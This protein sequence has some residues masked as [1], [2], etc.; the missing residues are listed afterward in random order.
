MTLQSE[1][2][3]QSVA[4]VQIRQKLY[5]L[6]GP[7]SSQSPSKAEAQE[8]PALVLM[9]VTV[10]VVQSER[11]PQSVRSVQIA[12][13]LNSLPGPPSSQSPS[14]IV[15]AQESALR[16]RPAL[17]LVERAMGGA[18]FASS[19]EANFETALR[20][21]EAWGPRRLAKNCVATPP[22]CAH[23]PSTRSSHFSVLSHGGRM[24]MRGWG[25]G[26]GAHA[27]VRTTALVWLTAL[28]NFAVVI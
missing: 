22:T 20:A 6:P 2:V 26:G 18:R 10:L 24:L 28:L 4:S 15:L 13:A 9:V 8:S 16:R 17:E 21:F 27:Q 14:P 1:R 11:G 3:P 25:R 23:R 7:P 12:Q 19:M 5:S